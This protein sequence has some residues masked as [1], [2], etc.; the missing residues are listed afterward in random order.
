MSG[1][2]LVYTGDGK[3]KTTAAV[4]LAARAL[5]RDMKVIMLQFIKSPDRDYGD[6]IALERLGCEVYQLG[7]GCT[8]TQSAEVNRAALKSAWQ[9]AKEVLQN[10]EYDVVILDELNIALRI[11]EFPIDDVIPL[12]EVLQALETKPKSTHIIIT[13]R[14]AKQEIK[15]LADLVSIVEE[16]KHYY[17]DGVQ[18]IYGV[19]Y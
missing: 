17:Q 18:A 4:G 19:D 9:K 10:E 1:K 16:D 12:S 5:G 15:N 14:D 13:G 7:A 6:Q 2:I 8:W 11:E 3:G